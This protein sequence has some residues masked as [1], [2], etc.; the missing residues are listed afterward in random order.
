MAAITRSTCFRMV[1]RNNDI[2]RR[3][4]H[5]DQ[6]S[7]HNIFVGAHEIVCSVHDR[8]GEV[9]NAELVSSE[10]VCLEHTW[11]LFVLIQCLVHK[12][13]IAPARS[14]TFFVESGQ[15]AH[16]PGDQVENV[17]VGLV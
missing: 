4:R 11:R 9:S 7:R 12:L 13:F 5:F 16:L 14:N 17:R 3:T 1:T 8:P 10:K 2:G 15:N 6:I